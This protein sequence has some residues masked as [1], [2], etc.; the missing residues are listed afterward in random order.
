VSKGQQ[1]YDRGKRIGAAG[2][3]AGTIGLAG[4]LGVAGNRYLRF[5]GK[6]GGKAGRIV[7]GEAVGIFTRPAARIGAKVFGGG[8]AKAVARLASNRRVKSASTRLDR[9]AHRTRAL[10]VSRGLMR[11]G[12]YAAIAGAGL[13]VY[14]FTQGGRPWKSKVK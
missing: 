4:G 2:G 14:G 5:G 6:S 12:G 8:R 11:Y 13:Q 3:L 9:F 1:W 7:L 10:R